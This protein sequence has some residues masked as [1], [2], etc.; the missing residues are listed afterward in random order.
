MQHKVIALAV[1]A[2]LAVGAS[3]AVAASM[4][5]SPSAGTAPTTDAV[6]PANHTVDVVDPDDELR[7]QDVTD[8]R[9]LALASDDVRRYVDDSESVSVE[10][11]APV[12]DDD[13]TSVWLAPNETAPTRVVVE[14]DLENDTIV[15]ITEPEVHS[16]DELEH[17]DVDDSELEV[18]NATDGVELESEAA[19][20]SSKIEF[21]VTG[22]SGDSD[23]DDVITLTS[24]DADT[25]SVNETEYTVVEDE[26]GP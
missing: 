26:T 10:V 14:V 9:Q 23:D 13:T 21:D 6:Q 7:S 12:T 2:L 4:T 22:D 18:E 15:G 8:A 16:A 25:I 11:F 17:F 24:D 1:A 20:D 3:G 5:T 19:N